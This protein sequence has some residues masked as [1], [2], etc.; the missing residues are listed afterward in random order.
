MEWM[1]WVLV[2]GQLACVAGLVLL[3]VAVRKGRD[4]DDAAA[5]ERLEQSRR[6][7]SEEFARALSESELRLDKADALRSEAVQRIVSLQLESVGKSVDGL[8]LTV[9]D[10]LKAVRDKVDRELSE[11][12]DRK[13]S[14][15]FQM[16]SESLA[17]VH[18]GLGEMHSLAKG[19]DDLGKVLGNVKTRGILGEVQLKAIISDILAKGQYEENVATVAGSAERVEFAVK[20]PVEGGFVWLPVDAKFPG[21]TY[22]ALQD[23]Y[24]SGD[25]AAINVAAKALCT[26]LRQEAKDI[27][28]KYL[29]VPE[30]TEFGVMFLPFEGLYAEAVNRGMVEVLQREY[31]VNIAGPSTMAA[32]LC[33]LQMSFRTIAIQRRSAE[34]WEVLGAVQSEFG[35]FEE[36]LGQAQNRIEQ[37]GRELEKLSG[38]RMNAMR[39]RLRGVSA[40]PDDV[41]A[42]VLGIED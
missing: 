11:H 9:R 12:L 22:A 15:S 41:A 32:M 39:R 17:K 25:G 10:G 7:Q 42:S 38:T 8:S 28:D 30:T 35:K 18:E 24:A 19:V 34:V 4:R 5:S 40:L 27:R 23:A 3:A 31:R 2:I 16:V 13:L 20:L 37:A 26:R 6:A 1:A 29:H 33:S 14:E 36:I 21:D